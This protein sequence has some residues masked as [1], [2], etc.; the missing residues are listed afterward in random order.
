MEDLILPV[1][2]NVFGTADPSVPW[3]AEM[4][5]D[6]QYYL[7]KYCRWTRVGTAKYF[8]MHILNDEIFDS[9]LAVLDDLSCQ[10]SKTYD[11]EEEE[12]G[13]NTRPPPQKRS[14]KRSLSDLAKRMLIQ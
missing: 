2:W 14:I 5:M 13:E 11:L 6:A 1:R 7:E 9:I 8:F 10:L 3:P 4:S 12:G